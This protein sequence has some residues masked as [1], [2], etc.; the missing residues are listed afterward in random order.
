MCHGTQARTAARRNPVS[1][2]NTKLIY[3]MIYAD[4]RSDLELYF[5]AIPA[6]ICVVCW[7]GV[8]TSEH[9]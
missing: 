7:Q 1:Q 6:F 9:S 3:P 4:L 2:G 5:L 8:V